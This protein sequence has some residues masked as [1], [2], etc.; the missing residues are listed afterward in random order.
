MENAGGDVVVGE[1]GF[2]DVATYTQIGSLVAEWSINGTG[3]FIGDAHTEFM[4]KKTSGSVVV[5]EVDGS[6]HTSYTQIASL[7]PEWTML[8]VGD[9]LG[10]GQSGTS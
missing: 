8:G 1:V 10:E 4:L 3:D 2:G 5:G 7:G 6:H 9:F